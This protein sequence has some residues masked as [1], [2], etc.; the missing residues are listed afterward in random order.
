[1]RT[2]AGSSA[3]HS[4]QQFRTFSANAMAVDVADR[5]GYRASQNRVGQDVENAAVER[6]QPAGQHECHGASARDK[7]KQQQSG[8]D[9]DCLFVTPL[10]ALHEAIMP[11]S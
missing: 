2:S 11:A 9:G 5:G 4:L 8:E 10:L 6:D 3:L 7:Q 1:M